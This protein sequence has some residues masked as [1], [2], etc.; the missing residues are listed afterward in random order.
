M[1]AKEYLEAYGSQFKDSVM[2]IYEDDI[3]KIMEGF[4]V[5]SIKSHFVNSNDDFDFDDLEDEDLTWIGE[6]C[7]K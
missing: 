5:E 7:K 4:A 6:D 1:T 3:I 2:G